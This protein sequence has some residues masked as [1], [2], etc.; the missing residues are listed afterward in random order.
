VSTDK[1]RTA[2]EVNRLG[3]LVADLQRDLVVARGLIR[4]AEN[5]L[6]DYI[7]QLEAKGS[8][9]HYGHSVLAQLRAFLG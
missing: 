8:M 6:A 3:A 4:E 5:A 2:D 9:L 1:K 7:P